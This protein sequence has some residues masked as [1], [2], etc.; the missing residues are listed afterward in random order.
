MPLSLDEKGTPQLGDLATLVVEASIGVIIGV[1][2]FF[3]TSGFGFWGS[4]PVWVHSLAE[5]GV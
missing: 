4:G 1:V 3:S 2:L 5:F